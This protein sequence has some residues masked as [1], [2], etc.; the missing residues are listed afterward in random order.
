MSKEQRLITLL[1]AIFLGF[2]GVH[3]FYEGKIGTGII[4]LFTGGF[5]G[6]GWFI[7]VILNIVKLISEPNMQQ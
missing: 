6:I 4:W 1:L 7:D 5:F 3:R 2:L